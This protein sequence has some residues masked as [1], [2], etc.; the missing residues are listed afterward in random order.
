MARQSM[1]DALEEVLDSWEKL[2]LPSGQQARALT[3]QRAKQVYRQGRI[4]NR[5][6]FKTL[7]AAVAGPLSTAS[8]RCA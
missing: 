4:R 6:P 8:R 1:A 3:S 5:A 7:D 2:D